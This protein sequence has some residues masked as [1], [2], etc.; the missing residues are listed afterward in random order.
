[1]NDAPARPVDARDDRRRSHRL[2][3]LPPLAAAT[4]ELLERL[5]VHMLGLV[6]GRP[7]HHVARRMVRL[8]PYYTCRGELYETVE[9]LREDRTQKILGVRLRN[10]RNPDHDARGI[11]VPLEHLDQ[12]YEPIFPEPAAEFATAA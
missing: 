3:S 11:E 8:A 9:P 5:A 6:P 7:H 2:A 12:A 10:A 1:M 4:I